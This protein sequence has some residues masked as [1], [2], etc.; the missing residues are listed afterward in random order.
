MADCQWGVTEV[1]VKKGMTKED[2]A[3]EAMFKM[4]KAST[5]KGM[6]RERQDKEHQAMLDRSKSRQTAL[7]GFLNN[8]LSRDRC[9]T[10]SLWWL[11]S[12]VS[13]SV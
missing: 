12:Q 7:R 1:P 10:V 6:Q 4:G 2:R 3:L 5:I 13:G 11:C 8:E 9:I